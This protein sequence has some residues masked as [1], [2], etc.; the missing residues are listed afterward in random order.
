MLRKVERLELSER[1][2]L[3]DLNSR[4]FRNAVGGYKGVV[5]QGP[6]IGSAA[7]A[8]YADW[9]LSGWTPDERR[10]AIQLAMSQA[11]LPQGR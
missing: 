1:R 11:S 6:G 5:S 2:Y 9:P 7:N 3:M 10:H 4:R 8:G